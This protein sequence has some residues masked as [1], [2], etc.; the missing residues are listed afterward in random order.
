MELKSISDTFR[1]S[2]TLISRIAVMPRFGKWNVRLTISVRSQAT[3]GQQEV[4]RTT[5]KVNWL[6][7]AVTMV[8]V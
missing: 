3:A 7:L 5:V 8:I 1:I 4:Y 6:F 2:E